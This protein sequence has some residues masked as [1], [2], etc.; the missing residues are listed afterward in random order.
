M[1]GGVVEAIVKFLEGPST[2]SLEN[3][4]AGKSI[5]NLD[6]LKLVIFILKTSKKKRTI[7]F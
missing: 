4:D 7:L 6:S 5:S 2:L 1:L 3:K